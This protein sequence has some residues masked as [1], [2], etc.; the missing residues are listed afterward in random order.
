MKRIIE[1]PAPQPGEPTGPTWWRSLDE[2]TERAEFKEWLHREFPQGASE[3]SGVNRRHFMRIMAASFAVAGLG[4]AGCRRPESTILPYNNDAKNPS[5]TVPGNPVFYASAFPDGTD[6][7]PLL[8]ETHHHRP[9]H[10]EGNPGYAP[11][12]GALHAIASASILNLYDPDRMTTSHEGRRR[13]NRERVRDRLAEVAATYSATGGQG[14][15]FL[16]EP[17]SSPSRARMVAALRKRYPRM[18]WAEYAPFATGNPELAAS[19]VFGGNLRP[20]YQFAAA[21]RIL[22]VDS[23]F[24]SREPGATGHTRAFAQTRK[25]R[26][27]EDAA[28]MSRL[29]CVE[30]AFTTT[31]TMADH[32]L[33]LASGQMTAFLAL[34]AREIIRQTGSGAV[35]SGFR[36]DRVA[37][38]PGVADSWIAECARDLLAH[39]GAAL[40]VPG[41]HL[42]VAAQ[43]LAILINELVGARGT[44]LVYRQLPTA[45]ATPITE[46]ADAI[47]AGRVDT[48]VVLGGNPVFNAPA[49]LDWARLQKSVAN[50]IRYGYYFDETSLESGFNIAATHYLESWGDCRTI[51]GTVLPVQPMIQPLF[52]GFQE[53][54][55][56]A[57]IAALDVWDAYAIVRDTF[58][59]ELLPGA[60]DR[61]FRKFLSDGLLPDSQYPLANVGLAG[62][63]LIT[64]LANADLAATTPSATALEV[65]LMRDDKVGD[66]FHTNNGWLQELPDPI[67]KLTWDN[68]ILISP[69]LATHLGYDTPS[70]TFLIGGVAKKNA[71]FERGREIAPVA[72]LSIGGVVVR[73]PIHIQPGLADW[74]VVIPCGYGRTQVGRVGR[75]AGFNGYP[76]S[77][78]GQPV[79]RNGASIALT[80]ATHRLAN[81]QMHWSMEGRAIVREANTSTHLQDPTWA[82][83]QGVEAHSPPIYGK[84]KDMPLA[85]KA[86][87]TPRGGSAYET[88]DFGAPPPNVKVWQDPAALAQFVPDQQWGMSID[89]NTCTGCNACV[90]ACQS[91]NNIPIVGKEQVMR[92]REMHWIRLDRYYTSGDTTAN[93]TS[94]PSDPQTA[95][96]PVGCL[97]CEMA[98]C[99]QVCP[100]NATV[101]DS[102]GLNVMAYNRCV[103]TR[104]CA[105]NCPYKVRRFNFFD[106]TKRAIDDFYKGPLATDQHK[107]E[108]GQ[109]VAMRANPEVSVRMRG[110][111]EKCTYCVQRIEQA[112]IA[113]RVVARDSNNIRIPDGVLRTACQSACPAEAIVFGDISDPDSAVSRAK[114][115]DRDYSLL[116]YLNTRP[117][118]TYLARLRN[119]NPLMPDYRDQPLSAMEYAAA[120]GAAHH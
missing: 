68:A 109:L 106:Y 62:P 53:L 52:D 114:D 76:L 91:E 40:V 21:K 89:L 96:M 37:S 119:P 59:S 38:L 14:L 111:M 4:A 35:W 63:R 99:E 46:L 15:A 115:N 12:G 72:E 17:S 75:G 101:H 90:I 19:A 74:T 29:Y 118:T 66:G 64:A 54:E 2:Y 1:H 88:P 51:D 31:G 36:L 98:P 80:R 95:I 42:P 28:A 67:T 87:T 79:V 44:T 105:N 73:G 5:G 30:S 34:V 55:V 22:A 77:T 86:L 82:H 69:A 94:L 45:P 97:H 3:A 10:V 48:L 20:I 50:V 104:Y 60:D 93:Q 6:A 116:G 120:S 117:R 92:G 81:T 102:Q 24:L 41:S 70:G 83:K 61:A 57:R 56:L 25:V 11:Y 7:L 18:V 9:T 108:G 85:Q 8:V 65:R 112:R 49:D 84:D 78:S 107:T 16:A 27:T 58:S 13:T 43:Q 110:V 32:R 100:V 39:K 23:D 103:G 47:R 71:R 33:R 113:Q 26:N